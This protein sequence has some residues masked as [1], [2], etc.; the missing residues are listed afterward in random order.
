MKILVV[1]D[2]PLINQYIVQ[3]IRTA[4]PTAEIIGAVTSGAKALKK[5]EETSA[6]LVFA[7]IT[8]P[9][10]DG[11]E[12][13]RTIKERW[14]ATD[15]IMLTCHD[16]FAYARA[17]IQNQASNY[18]LKNE[19]DPALLREVLERLRVSHKA[20]HTKQGTSHISRNQYLRDLIEQEGG[21]QPVR[22]SALRENHIYLEDRTFAVFL[23]Y[24]DAGNIRAVQESLPDDFENPLFYDYE[25]GD[26]LLLL[27]L[28]SGETDQALAVFRALEHRLYGVTGLSAAHQHLES[29]PRAIHEAF[30]DRDQRFYGS[31]GQGR[32]SG[33]SATQLE[34]YIMRAIIKIEDQAI[35]EGCAEIEKLLEFSARRHPPAALLKGLVI[36]VLSG[37]QDKHGLLAECPERQIIDSRTFP[38]FCVCVRGLL[39]GLRRNSKRY[40][41][42]IRKALDYIAVHYAEDISLNA[43]ADVVYLNRDYLSRQFKKE[44]GVNFSEY[45]TGLRMQQAKN[46]LET[47][48]MRISD[49]ALRVGMSNMSY[50]STVFH[51]AFGCTPN[52]ARKRSG[53][54]SMSKM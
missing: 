36:Q 29:L 32:E 48:S 35:E 34:P 28:P 7:D 51:R 37:I 23:F 5:L 33:V 21:A 12:L 16:D 13:L 8:M 25:N 27:N 17:A 47:T 10:M 6:D 1:D 11:I 3:C 46:L 38:D 45:L 9:K 2:E 41:E 22:E 53:A 26:M 44:V 43:V 20:Q 24:N 39:E 31:A 52:E 40:S 18:I 50:F 4:D 54:G 30:S 49:V 15:V 19:V 14:P 42:P